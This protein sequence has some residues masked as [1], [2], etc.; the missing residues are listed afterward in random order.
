MKIFDHKFLDF[1]VLERKDTDCGRFYITDDGVS[2][3][4]VTTV[5]S[6]LNSNALDEWKNRVG[7]E[8]A[9]KIG[10]IA[11]RKG[12]SVHRIVE[13]FLKNDPH[14]LAREMPANIAAFSSLKQSLYDHVDTVYGIEAPLYSKNLCCAGTADLICTWD[15][16]PT[17]VDIKT[18]SKLKKEEWILNYFIQA[19]CYALM[20][21]ELFA[22]DIKQILII[23]A[24]ADEKK[25]QLFLKNVSEYE[26]LTNKIFKEGLLPTS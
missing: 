10:S 24:V 16:Q 8:Q 4:S 3:P 20:A 26:T 21:N 6:A 1:P 15:Q 17:I 19:T 2:L 13:K 14:Y 12:T 22:L 7:T 9:E 25:P 5:L 18:S 11:K 23:I